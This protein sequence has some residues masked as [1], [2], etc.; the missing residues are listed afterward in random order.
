MAWLAC[1]WCCHI[2]PY[3]CSCYVCQVGT[4]VRAL[5]DADP[6]AAVNMQAGNREQAAGR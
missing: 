1:W 2:M 3:M 5:L 4:T 6:S